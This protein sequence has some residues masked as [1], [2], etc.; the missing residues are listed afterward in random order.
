MIVDRL[1]VFGFDDISIDACFG[2]QAR[3]NIA[4]LDAASGLGPVGG[5]A[6]PVGQRYPEALD[7]VH[8]ARGPRSSFRALAEDDRGA[9]DRS[10]YRSR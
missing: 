10:A 7:V 9:S 1:E 4:A 5:R 2:V 6:A 8:R 3:S